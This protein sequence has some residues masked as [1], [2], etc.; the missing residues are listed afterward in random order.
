MPSEMTNEI[1]PVVAGIVAALLA[2]RVASPRRRLTVFAALSI[3][4]GVTASWAS[5]EL[6]VSWGYVLFDIGQVLVS[7][8]LTLLLAAVWQ[9]RRRLAS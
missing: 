3:L 1:F 7:G 5:G 8:A 9:R 2:F 4:F 6:S